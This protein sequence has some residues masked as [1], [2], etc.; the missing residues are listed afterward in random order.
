[1][2]LKPTARPNEEFCLLEAGGRCLAC[3]FTVRD[4][5]SAKERLRPPCLL[6]R[7]CLAT[8]APFSDLPFVDVC[9]K[10]ACSVPCSYEVPPV[11]S[12]DR[13]PPQ[14]LTLSYSYSM[15]TSFSP[16]LPEEGERREKKIALPNETI[17]SEARFDSSA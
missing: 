7:Q 5:G 4:Q 10:C 9:G 12:I 6:H 16:P 15:H 3:V 11:C 8:D 13:E 14:G 1:M 17:L 2:E